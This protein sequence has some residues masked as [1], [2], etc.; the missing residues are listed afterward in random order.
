MANYTAND[1]DANI[2][3]KN[4][5]YGAYRK[6]IDKI[7]D[8]RGNSTPIVILMTPM[9]RGLFGHSA[10]LATT[11]PPDGVANS[12]GYF[13]SQ[14][15][16]MVQEIAL[17]EGLPCLDLFN[18]GVVPRRFLNQ[19]TTWD[20]TQNGGRPANYQDIF[21]DNLHPTTKGHLLIGTKLLQ[22]V[23]EKLPELFISQKLF[24]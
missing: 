23:I 1:F 10:N 13:L 22:K 7:L 17:Y 24:S 9:H 18:D 2:S 14:F 15:A 3:A 8:G 6:I 16:D 21:Y 19:N 5:S 12:K 20:T 4:T 11:A